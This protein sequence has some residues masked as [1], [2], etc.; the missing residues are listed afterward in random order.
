[1]TSFRLGALIGAATLALGMGAGTAAAST[2]TIKFEGD[3]T[4]PTYAEGDF[5]VGG[6]SQSSWNNGNCYL[7]SCIQEAQEG[8]IATVAHKDGLAF[9]LISFYFHLQGVSG[10]GGDDIYEN[11]CTHNCVSVY[12]I[13]EATEILLASFVVRQDV[14]DGT[15]VVKSVDA[16]S[17]SVIAHNTGYIATFTP[18]VSGLTLLSFNSFPNA[19]VRIDEIT[20][21]GPQTPTPSAVPLPAAG[22][23][24]IGGLGAL[25]AVRRRT[26]AA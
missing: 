24:L 22:W 3:Q 18:E 6:L 11:N 1:M 15:E 23:L 16:S 10:G 13:S 21:R 26:K 9:D 5:I 4:Q 7:G 19:N 12:D 2:Y 25:A 8:V 20:L 17:V 14:P